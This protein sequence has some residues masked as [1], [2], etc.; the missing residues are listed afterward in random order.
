MIWCAMAANKIVID[1]SDG[2]ITLLSA[3]GSG[4]RMQLTHA[5]RKILQ[6]DKP[7]GIVEEVVSIIKQHKLEG[8]EFYYCLD[9]RFALVKDFY[10]PFHSAPKIDKALEFELK[11]VLPAEMGSLHI[12]WQ[13]GCRD[14][15]GTWVT[16]ACIKK[17]FFTELIDGFVHAGFPPVEIRLDAFVLAAAAGSVSSGYSA[18][19][20]LGRNRTLLMSLENGSLRRRDLLPY[21]IEDIIKRLQKD[22]LSYDTA[23]RS[24]FTHDFSKMDDQSV[25]IQKVQD[26][27]SSLLDGID[28]R[29]EINNDKMGYSPD[30]LLLCGEGAEITGITE[31]VEREL[32]LQAR[33]LIEKTDRNPFFENPVDSDN[34]LIAYYLLQQAK[35]RDILSFM[36]PELRNLAS[37][38]GLGR[39]RK[40]LISAAVIAGCMLIAFGASIFDSYRT[41]GSYQFEIAKVFNEYLPNVKGQFSRAQYVS[42]LKSRIRELDEA[43]AKSKQTGSSAIETLKVLHTLVGKDVKV[44]MTDLS[45]DPRRITLIGEAPN[46]N[47][48]ESL[49]KKIA[50]GNIFSKVSIRSANTEAKTKRVRFELELMRNVEAR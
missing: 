17:D 31:F 35:N 22:E 24:L 34:Y 48:V 21:G 5:A 3:T 50:A 4:A 8:K 36:T 45:L 43:L 40:E 25:V 27:L 20:S 33:L 11:N 41:I 15:K 46:Y 6:S 1:L 28:R 9:S 12:E 23:Y 42:I 47:T 37:E 13:Y 26:A 7:E 30:S 39:F 19:L 10:F 2:F 49:R 14:P 32:G 29:L 44:E 38:Q 18:V 16:V